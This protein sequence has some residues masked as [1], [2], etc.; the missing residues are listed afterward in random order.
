M[1]LADLYKTAVPVNARMFL[2][3]I[4]GDRSPITEKD[5]STEEIAGIKKAVSNRKRA[6]IQQE[7]DLKLE[8]DRYNNGMYK[9]SPDSRN[10]KAQLEAQLNSY[11][12][13]RDRTSFG[14]GDYDVKSGEN[15]A[16][17]LQ[18]WPSAIYQSYTDPAF[19]LSAT[20]GSAKYQE[21]NGK[22]YV[23][24]SYGFAD[25]PVYKRKSTDSLADIFSMYKDN[26]GA[27]GELLY[28]KYMGGVRR[29]V[30][31]NLD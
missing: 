13:T 25:N 24:D 14:Y 7:S 18:G 2:N 26:P 16:P 22:P 1:E 20:L 4:F 12:T 29:P 5:F 9:D 27:L 10:R 3:T 6:N 17:I 19:R 15:A 28:T 31:I 11:A 30:K 23:E 21:N 8:L